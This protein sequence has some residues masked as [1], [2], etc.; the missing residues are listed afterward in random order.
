M[1]K[2]MKQ[3]IATV[4]V[5]CSMFGAASVAQ[6][7]Q[8]ATGVSV[9]QAVDSSLARF[10]AADWRELQE[11]AARSG[12]RDLA[13]Y[14][15]GRAMTVERGGTAATPHGWTSWARK[16]A[17]YALRHS[18][19]K[20]PAKIRPYAGKIANILETT[21]NWEKTAVVWA[22]MRAG[23]PGDVAIYTADWLVLFLG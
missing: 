7:A 23:I 5:A 12:Q 19:S 1:K 17:I 22:L 6:P 21:I 9:E 14:F 4:T 13:R 10:T 20:L 8:A 16:A 11:S 15:A 2:S 3:A 18:T